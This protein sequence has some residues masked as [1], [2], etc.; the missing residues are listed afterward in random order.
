MSQIYTVICRASALWILLSA[1]LAESVSG[2]GGQGLQGTI[3][4]QTGAV[5]PGVSVTATDLGT[6]IKREA[7]SNEI[8]L[9][10]FLS[11]RVGSYQVQTSLAGFIPHAAFCGS[12]ID[13]N[14]FRRG[15]AEPPKVI[16]TNPAAPTMTTV[17]TATKILIVLLDPL[18]LQVLVCAPAGPQPHSVPR[19]Q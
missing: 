6:Q 9:Y 16:S 7:I 12:G 8:G 3:K 17:Q 2:Q 14:A 15:S 18:T 11:L 1:V 5:L 19:L 13:R 10:R 4:D